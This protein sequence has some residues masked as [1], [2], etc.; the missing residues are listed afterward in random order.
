[1]M[2]SMPFVILQQAIEEQYG[3]RQAP[4]LTLVGVETLPMAGL[5]VSVDAV[6]VLRSQFPDRQRLKGE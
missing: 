2:P 1:M 5:L 6:A 3:A 4:A